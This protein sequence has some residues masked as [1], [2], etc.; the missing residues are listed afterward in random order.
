MY[1]VR[2]DRLTHRF[3]ILGRPLVVV[4]PDQSI[5]VERRRLED[6]ARRRRGEADHDDRRVVAQIR[7]DAAE[8][9]HQLRLRVDPDR[10]DE[11]QF[12]RE[13]DRGGNRVAIR[14]G[15]QRGAAP[16]RSR[17][18]PHLGLRVA[19]GE[20]RTTALF[21]LAPHQLFLLALGLALFAFLFLVDRFGCFEFGDLGEFRHHLV[22]IGALFLVVA[23]FGGINGRRA[24][25]FAVALTAAAAIATSA[26]ATAAAALA[27]LSAFTALR[28]RRRVDA[29]GILAARLGAFFVVGL[30]SAFVPFCAIPCDRGCT[31][32][33]A[34]PATTPAAAPT[35]AIRSALVTPAA[36]AEIEERELLV[37]GTRR[38]FAALA[39]GR[40]LVRADRAVRRTERH[41][42]EARSRRLG[43]R[44]PLEA[45]VAFGA[46]AA[47]D[48][49]R[50]EFRRTARRRTHRKFRQ[51]ARREARLAPTARRFE[52]TQIDVDQRQDARRCVVESFGR[53]HQGRTRCRAG[54]RQD[55]RDAR[56]ECRPRIECGTE[57]GE[58]QLTA[59]DARDGAPLGIDAR[60][61]DR[62][63]RCI[64]QRPTL[65]IAQIEM[66]EQRRRQREA[67]TRFA[68]ARAAI[69]QEFAQRSLEAVERVGHAVGEQP[70]HFAARFAHFE[71][72]ACAV[73][74]QNGGDA[75][76]EEQFLAV[77]GRPH[78]AAVFRGEAG[79]R[80]RS[81]LVQRA[82]GGIA[83][84][85][86]GRGRA[87]ERRLE[88][89]GLDTAVRLIHR[90]LDP[91]ANAE[92]CRAEQTEA[93][94]R[95]ER[96]ARRD[97]DRGAGEAIGRGEARRDRERGEPRV[98]ALGRHAH[99][100]SPAV[101]RGTDT[102]DAERRRHVVT[103]RRFECFCIHQTEA[104]HA[105]E[106]LR[107]VEPAVSSVV[108]AATTPAPSPKA[109]SHFS[110]PPQPARSPSHP[111]L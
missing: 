6:L 80:S 95:G 81:A 35:R 32:A 40:R 28:L 72:D 1:G 19:L 101:A 26:P 29:F 71:R 51:R 34:A 91:R 102:D 14:V 82:R 111:P 45:F 7:R 85:R 9:R 39:F 44:S 69:T 78:R 2:T 105:T 62:L 23:A 65:R 92:R 41:R 56:H 58:I 5:A 49:R 52:R 18:R 20:T 53:H 42:G 96:P 17:R 99:H 46:L 104:Q 55:R 67:D 11:A 57:R 54:A 59:R 68:L 100:Q 48:R 97:G 90:G 110:S 107:G 73:A 27:S 94:P 43:R 61:V 93:A 63:A 106:F 76:E 89:L 47:I 88:R 25:R 15:E 38:G 60:E 70:Q 37:T 84:G 108:V 74:A 103:G 21:A 16:R 8:E 22:E 98:A 75:A 86:D 24:R 79:Q 64:R 3:E 77:G 87:E 36:L 50:G 83:A 13:Q 66:S 12:A 4:V 30:G 109:S 33:A 31:R 10:V